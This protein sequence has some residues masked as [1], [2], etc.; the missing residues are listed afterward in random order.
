MRIILKPCHRWQVQF[1]DLL[2]PFIMALLLVTILEP[3]K[4]DCGLRS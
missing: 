2:L 3:I 1:A 4:Q